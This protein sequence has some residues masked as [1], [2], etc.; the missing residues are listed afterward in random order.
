MHH[1]CVSSLPFSQ[2]NIMLKTSFFT[3]SSLAMLPRRSFATISRRV[4]SRTQLNSNSNN[5][6]NL[7]LNLSVVFLNMEVLSKS[8][9]NRLD[10]L[11]LSRTTVRCKDSSN[12]NSLNLPPSMLRINNIKCSR[13]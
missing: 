4:D 7:L 2:T 3:T 6:S 13:S 11:R 10:L 1:L 5:N 9:S 8:N 12:F